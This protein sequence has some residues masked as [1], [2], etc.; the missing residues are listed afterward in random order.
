MPTDSRMSQEEARTTIS[1]HET[2]ALGDC[3]RCG[4]EPWGPWPC[5]TRREAERAIEREAAE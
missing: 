2:N 1:R 5:E 4:A 3:I